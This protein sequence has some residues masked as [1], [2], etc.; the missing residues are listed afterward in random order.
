MPVKN[1]KYYEKAAV[2]CSYASREGKREEKFSGVGNSGKNLA[3][4]HRNGTTAT[5]YQVHS[6]AFETGIK[7]PS[8]RPLE[9][10]IK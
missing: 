8:D 4:W 1:T 7:R 9:H 10:A 2:R 5:K 3:R 6:T